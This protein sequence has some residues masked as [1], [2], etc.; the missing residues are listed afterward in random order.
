MRRASHEPAPKSA[1]VKFAVYVADITI[2][3]MVAVHALSQVA[4]SI[5]PETETLLA[6]SKASE[7]TDLPFRSKTL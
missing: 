4:Q 5:V 3:A 6:D 1:R 2:F 7:A